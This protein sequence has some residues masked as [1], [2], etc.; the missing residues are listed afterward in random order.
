LLALFLFRIPV[1]GFILFILGGV[2]SVIGFGKTPK[3]LAKA[4][5]IISFVVAAFFILILLSRLFP[6]PFS[7]GM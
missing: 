1:F 6:H 5:V 3:G 7:L 2:F 4:G